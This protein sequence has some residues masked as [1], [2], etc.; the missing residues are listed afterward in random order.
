MLEEARDEKE[1]P[2]TTRPDRHLSATTVAASPTSYVTVH[3]LRRTREETGQEGRPHPLQVRQSLLYRLAPPNNRHGLSGQ[4]CK[5]GATL[6][7]QRNITSAVT[8]QAL[9]EVAR[10]KTRPR[11]LDQAI[12]PTPVVQACLG[13]QVHLALSDRRVILMEK[14]PTMNLVRRHHASAVRYAPRMT[15]PPRGEVCAHHPLV[16]CLQYK[17]NDVLLS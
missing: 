12:Q 1:I 3:S 2:R 9:Q 14:A 4:L 6:C 13:H 5:V 7:N 16:L 17:T 8:S 15:H 10:G 11:V